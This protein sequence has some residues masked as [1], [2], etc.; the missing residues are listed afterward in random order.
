MVVLHQMVE[1]DHPTFVEALT[2]GREKEGASKKRRRI[3]STGESKSV[4][5]KAM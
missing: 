3:D 1:V 5:L 4:K 2:Y